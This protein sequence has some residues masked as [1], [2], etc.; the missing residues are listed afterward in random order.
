MEQVEQRPAPERVR[1]A[2]NM[3][4]LHLAGYSYDA[5]EIFRPS[6]MTA[7]RL[8]ELLTKKKNEL[9][10]KGYKKEDFELRLISKPGQSEPVP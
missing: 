6:R 9:L 8:Q 4:V 2:F 1:A 5:I 10:V 3:V 7:D